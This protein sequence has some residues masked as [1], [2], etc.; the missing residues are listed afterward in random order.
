MEESEEVKKEEESWLRGTST[1]WFKAAWIDSA[2]EEDE[3]GSGCGTASL[4]DDGVFAV[5][6]EQEVR[7]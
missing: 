5:N 7:E 6:E 2:R 1:R 4:T 3:E